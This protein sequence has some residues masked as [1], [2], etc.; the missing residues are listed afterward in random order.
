MYKSCF[1][2]TSRSHLPP[3][4]TAFGDQNAK[5]KVEK[6]HHD[7]NFGQISKLENFGKGPPF[8]YL[9]PACPLAVHS[10]MSKP[11]QVTPPPALS[12]L[13]HPV[14]TARILDTR[15]P[16]TLGIQFAPEHY[17]EIKCVDPSAVTVSAGRSIKNEVETVIA[18]G[19]T[20]LPSE[21]AGAARGPLGGRPSPDAVRQRKRLVRSSR[22]RIK[23]QSAAL[24]NR[25]RDRQEFRADFVTLSQSWSAHQRHLGRMLEAQ[26][27]SLRDLVK[28]VQDSLRPARTNPIAHAAARISRNPVPA[29]PP[30]P[31]PSTPNTSAVPTV[32]PS[33]PPENGGAKQKVAL[34]RRFGV[35]E[36]F[37]TV[38]GPPSLVI[39]ATFNMRNS[40]PATV[41]E[42]EAKSVP[43]PKQYTRCC[44]S[45]RVPSSG[46]DMRFVTFYPSPARL[47]V[48]VKSFTTGLVASQ[49]F[50][51]EPFQNSPIYGNSNQRQE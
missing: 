28:A 25:N 18:A 37:R 33:A 38:E 27:Y 9:R 20:G 47:L 45:V 21:L 4:R 12:A 31:P 16:F 17:L 3:T 23:V 13:P 46:K 51:V 36:T 41:S 10:S 50:S 29:T 48:A 30:P 7:S 35:Y 42:N 22:Q 39:R 32:V 49:N 26:R 15:D 40:P 43:P 11:S 2:G 34:L 8:W 19:P 1:L 14:E 44:F 24:L 6:S 5:L